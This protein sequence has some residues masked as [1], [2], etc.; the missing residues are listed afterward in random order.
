MTLF[1]MAAILGPGRL[2]TPAMM[3]ENAQCVR[4]VEARIFLVQAF[5]GPSPAAPGYGSRFI[6]VFR[7]GFPAPEAFFSSRI[8]ISV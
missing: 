7:G 6:G 4:S 3:H 1:R 5:V 2:V 8:G